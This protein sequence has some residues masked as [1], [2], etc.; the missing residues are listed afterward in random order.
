M[1]S[2][3]IPP[4]RHYGPYGGTAHTTGQLSLVGFCPHSTLYRLANATSL[5]PEMQRG[6][7]TVVGQ[8]AD[9]QNTPRVC[10]NAKRH[11]RLWAMVL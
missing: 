2:P 11:V 3:L 1:A 7:V 9:G 10:G 6:A 8:R 5:L 4:G